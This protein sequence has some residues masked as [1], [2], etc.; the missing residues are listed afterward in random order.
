MRAARALQPPLK[1][2]ERD[3]VKQ[4]KDFLAWRGWR[5]VRMQR[6]ILPGSFQTGEP[7]MADYL[8][9]RYSPESTGACLCLWIEFKRPGGPMRQGQMEWH[10]R[11]RIRGAAVWVVEELDDFMTLYNQHFGYLHPKRK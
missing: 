8:F 9:L 10:E 4:V 11:E 1:L 3:V 6:M 2:K 5:A 7:G